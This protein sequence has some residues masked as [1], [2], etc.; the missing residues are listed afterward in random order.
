MRPSSITLFLT[1]IVSLQVARSKALSTEFGDISNC[2]AQ[3]YRDS[4]VGTTYSSADQP[5]LCTNVTMREQFLGC[6]LQDCEIKESLLAHNLTATTCQFPVRDRSN[7]INVVAIVLT[8]LSALLV[9]QRFAFKLYARLEIYLDDWCILFCLLSAIASTFLNIYGSA[10]SG[11]GRDVWTLQPHQITRFATFFFIQSFLYFFQI[12]SIKIA[13]LF[14][15]LR[16]FPSPTTRKVLYGTLAVTVAFLVTF[17]IQALVTCRPVSHFWNRWD[18]ERE[19]HCLNINAGTW[20]HSAIS[21]ALSIWILAIPLHQIGGLQLGRKK[22]VGA[23]L[24]FSVGIFDIVVSILRLSELVKHPADSYNVTWEF[25]ECSK[26]SIIESH[27]GSICA[28]MPSFRLFLVRL[29]CSV[30]GTSKDGTDSANASGRQSKSRTRPLG[31][32][33]T[34]VAGRGHQAIELPGISYERSFNVEYSENDERSLVQMDGLDRQ[35]SVSEPE[36]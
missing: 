14:F 15:Y 34:L 22:K 33:S 1:I 16:I 9:M 23:S 35:V 17:M 7:E 25:T 5:W 26:W 27:V 30:L 6:M 24:M 10:P 13:L 28:C 32:Q 29:F 11:L 2:T 18:G 8:I 3:C 4:S 31:T 36:P 19:G 12:V 21:I 20:S